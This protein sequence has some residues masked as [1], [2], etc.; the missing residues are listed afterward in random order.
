MAPWS[1]TTLYIAGFSGRA[2]PAEKTSLI[3][4]MP[5]RLCSTP[6][7]PNPATYRGR[8]KG[9]AKQRNRDTHRNRQIYNS[10]R[11]K[12][13]RRAVLFDEPLCQ[14]G[15]IATDVDHIIPIEQGGDP[16]SRVNLQPLC[17]SCH[18]R[19]TKREMMAA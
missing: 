18:G 8:C 19:K 10:R 11:W 4:R 15:E 16:Y 17:F 9:H 13:L 1:S 6:K 14:C 5:T 3:S 12:Y 7:C 2:G